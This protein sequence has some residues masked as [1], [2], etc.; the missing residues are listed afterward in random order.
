MAMINPGDIDVIVQGYL[1]DCYIK[2]VC[3][4]IRTNLAGANIILSTWKECEEKAEGLKKLHLVDEY[5]LSEDPGGKIQNYNDKSMNNLSRQIVS[6]KAALP[7]VSREFVL[8]TRTDIEIVSSDFLSRYEK[9]ELSWENKRDPQKI[10][11]DHFLLVSSFYSR[12]VK[13]LPMA[14]HVSDWFTFGQK[15][16]VVALYDLELPDENYYNWFLRHKKRTWFYK[17][18]MCQ[19]AAEQYFL[20]QALKRKSMSVQIPS[21]YYSVNGTINRESEWIISNNYI[22]E[23]YTNGSFKFLK[24]N[25]NKF[26]DEFL[27]YRSDDLETIRHNMGTLNEFG[28]RV[29]YS[30]YCIRTLLFRMYAFCV[31]GVLSDILGRTNLKKVIK[32]KLERGTEEAKTESDSSF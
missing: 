18:Y 16:D 3:E 27:C 10:L 24:Y 7:Y 4:S 2:K 6:V 1:D 8:K 11:F 21:C 20:I 31:L 13:I 17:D 30:L 9:E 12:N 23:D 29:K 28:D 19:Y 26:F 32:K 5:V 14:Y 15:R 22:I 25:P